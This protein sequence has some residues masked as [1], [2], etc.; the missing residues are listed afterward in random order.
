MSTSRTMA[1]RRPTPAWQLRIE[2]L[3]VTPRVWRRIVVPAQITLPRLDRVLQAAMGWTNSH[4][5]EFV[6]NGTRYAQ[7]DPEW[8][9]DLQQVDERR[10]R[11]DEALGANSRCFD[12]VY[13]FGDDWHHVVTV[14]DLYVARGISKQSVYCTDGERACPPEDVGGAGGYEDFLTAIADPRHE[15]HRSYLAWV[16]GSFDPARFDVDVVNRELARLKALSR[17]DSSELRRSFPATRR[18]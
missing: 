16:G 13:D 12:Y 6:I 5:H 2:L 1:K 9:E 8:A 17:P 3:D 10:V 11:L 18:D 7:Y 4:L 14:E 15:E